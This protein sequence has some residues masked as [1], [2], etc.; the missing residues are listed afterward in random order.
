MRETSRGRTN[1]VSGPTGRHEK[2]GGIEAGMKELEREKHNAQI[3]ERFR[4]LR[5]AEESQFDSNASAQ[6]QASA[7][8]PTYTYTAP[9]VNNTPVMAQTPN[10]TEFVPVMLESPVFTTEK[11]T[12]V[13]INAGTATVEVQEINE[14]NETPAAPVYAGMTA[15]AVEE[16]FSL[17]TKAKMV[18]GAVAA[19][20]V[21]MFSMVGINTQ[22]IKNNAKQIKNLEKIRKQLVDQNAELE[23][24]IEMA[25][26]E[27]SIREYLIA[28][29]II[30]G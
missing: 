22:I 28:Q 12:N 8:T 13:A 9:V 25:Q 1:L 5:E 29:G 10:V 26:S 30:Q 24:R 20:F 15:T 6:T 7:S 19:T 4:R 18:I 27:E 16:S 21:L 2:N 3:Q 14:I 23:T 17:P 11:Y